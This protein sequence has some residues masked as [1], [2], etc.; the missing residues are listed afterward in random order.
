MTTYQPIRY[1]PADSAEYAK[2]YTNGWRASQRACDWNGIGL[3]PLERADLRNVSHAW[4]DGW[5]DWAVGNAKWTK[6]DERLAGDHEPEAVA[7]GDDATDT[8]NGYVCSGWACTDCLF[9][10]ANGDEPSDM[11]SE[12]QLAAWR[13]HYQATTRDYQVTLGMLRVDHTCPE[14]TEECDCEVIPFS[15]SRC[16]VC[17]TR[18]GGERHAVSFFTAA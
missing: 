4:Y 16:D 10:L 2:D 8:P 1:I 17:G 5:E 11:N 3:S 7:Q 12:A 15:G 9:M 14:G 18:L 6:R 13:E